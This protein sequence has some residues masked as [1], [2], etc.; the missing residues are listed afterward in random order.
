MEPWARNRQ[1]YEQGEAHL[2]PLTL[3][4]RPPLARFHQR[5]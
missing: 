2:P 4:D 3:E 5:L 1:R